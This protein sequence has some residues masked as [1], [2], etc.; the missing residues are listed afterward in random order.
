MMLEMQFILPH[1]GVV[2]VLS[3]GPSAVHSPKLIFSLK[4]AR[5]DRLCSMASV[6]RSLQNA[7]LSLSGGNN[8]FIGMSSQGICVVDG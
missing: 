2:Q 1:A 5:G 8:H 6:F 3:W 7:N 4:E